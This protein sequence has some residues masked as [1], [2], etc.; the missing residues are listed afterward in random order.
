MAASQFETKVG[1][2]INGE[3]SWTRG[4]GTP[5]ASETAEIG[6]IYSDITN[7]DLWKKNTGSGNTGWILLVSTLEEARAGGS[8]ISGNIDFNNNTGTNVADPVNPQ[9][10]A[11]KRFVES[12]AQGL[13]Q[14]ES[15]RVATIAALD[16]NT[17]AGSG[18]GK[19]I[20]ANG[21]GI[22]SID[23]VNTG[24]IDI[25]TDGGINDPAEP[26]ATRA[27][28]VLV[29]DE[30]GSSTHHGI[31]VVKDKGTAGTPWIL[32]RAI[33]ADEDNEVTAQL[34]TFVS[35]GT[36]A[37]TGWSISTSDA[38]T[39]DTT[40]I[41]FS[42]FNGAGNITAGQGLDKSGNDMFVGDNDRGIQANA[43][44]LEFSA[45][46]VVE[47]GLEVGAS[48]WKLKVKPDATGGANLAASIDVNS[49]G[50]A[51]KVDDSSIQENGSGQLEILPSIITQINQASVATTSGSL[52][53]PS[54]TVLESVTV[55]DND[56]ATDIDVVEW[57]VRVHEPANDRKYSAV[58]NALVDVAGTTVDFSEY[59]SNKTGTGNIPALAFDVVLVGSALQLRVT[60]G[61]ATIV[62]RTLRRTT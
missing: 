36:Q 9:D 3:V 35:E 53:D 47:N 19:T 31:Y 44:D 37:G 52:V 27:S 28:R 46:E 54:A 5:E 29:K 62:V 41:T 42:Q 61:T 12:M 51:I 8:Q 1:F 16:A 40:A 6:S 21:N 45:S 17:P 50:V 13:D 20:T 57:I 23:G 10:I 48:A 38:I 39:V 14:K 2:T 49:N 7:G 15:V 56:G 55:S 32:V 4:S 25:D 34:Y 26:S 11:N 59:G 60:T 22:L 18:I 33:D 43:N 58:I 30:G 24:W